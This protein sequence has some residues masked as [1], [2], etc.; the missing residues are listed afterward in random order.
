MKRKTGKYI[1]LFFIMVI[2]DFFNLLL[3]IGSLND[4]PLWGKS[5]KLYNLPLKFRWGQHT[6][7]DQ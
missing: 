1:L 7:N 5:N 4:W 6:V 3:L 2:T